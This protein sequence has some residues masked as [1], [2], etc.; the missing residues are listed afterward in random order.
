M[1]SET[2]N[3][4]DGILFDVSPANGSHSRL[5]VARARDGRA[6]SDRIDVFRAKARERFAEHV[7]KNFRLDSRQ[8]T[9]RIHSTLPLLAEWADQRAAEESSRGET[10][11]F[12]VA[13]V[14]PWPEPV[15]LGDALA[16]ALA[17][18]M[19]HIF[20]GREAAVACALWAAW[21][22]IFDSFDVAPLLVL[23]S[24]VKR[25]GKTS[26]L[27][28]ISQFVARPLLASNISPAAS[29]RVIEGQRPTLIVDEADTFLTSNEELRGIINS[30][31]TRD[32]AYVLRANPVNFEPERFSTWCPKLIAAIGDLPSTIEDR[33]VVI[34]LERKP[35]SVKLARLGRK[36]KEELQT[37]GRKFARW[38]KDHAETIDAD[39][40]P[41]N[42]PQ[43][44]NDR[45]ADNWRPLLILADCAAGEWPAMA[46]KA[47]E[48]LSAARDGDNDDL[49]V[50]LLVD[51]KI[52]FSEEG[53]DAIPACDLVDQ[54]CRMEE[55]PWATISGGRPLTP[56][57]L[58]RMLRKFG[59]RS[60]KGRTNNMY[61]RED[62][63]DKW[64]RYCPQYGGQSGPVDN[65]ETK[66]SP[67]L[68]NQ[69]STPPQVDVSVNVKKI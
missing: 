53:R 46:R 43:G 37:I 24:P 23:V 1:S 62:L 40:E 2:N 27:S 5:V 60:R 54:L 41:D 42:P 36:T 45:A 32:T 34:S 68:P 21:T 22:H 28:V 10:R 65:T 51:L 18:I 61:V 30:G 31:H 50:R 55:A 63:T 39:A 20:I 38:A 4:S 56:Q 16:E 26:L 58:S 48:I 8:I 7:A 47:A 49:L 33:A 12:R 25:C 14:E 66:K 3:S 52:I 67:Y 17:A 64:E 57:K 13:D 11:I 59:V 15:A 9:E 69:T 44:L 19:R 6:F 29:Y 35:P